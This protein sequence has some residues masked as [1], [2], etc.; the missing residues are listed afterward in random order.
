MENFV[1]DVEHV[2]LP[3]PSEA[4]PWK[5]R[6]I[7]LLPQILENTSFGTYDEH[8]DELERQSVEHRDEGVDGV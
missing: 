7:L 2:A 6:K 5:R 1:A 4:V 3:D 8:D